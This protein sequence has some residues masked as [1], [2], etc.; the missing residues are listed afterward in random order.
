VVPRAY[1]AG[2]NVVAPVGQESSMV[3][4]KLERKLVDHLRDAHAMERNVLKMLDGMTATTSDEKLRAQLLHHSGETE[5][6]LETI[7]ARL[8]AHGASASGAKD[9]V[10][11]AGGTLSAAVMK[12]M[13]QITGD[14]R[15]APNA[16]IGFVTEHMEIAAYEV[17]ERIAVRAGDQ[18]TAHAA[19]RNRAE[20]EAMADW[21]AAGWD[22]VVDLMLAEE[23]LTT[24]ASG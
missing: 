1:S 12:V 10:A 5:R 8:R 2:Q 22:R 24:T 7:E 15:A 16:R 6:H 11:L 13:A 20:E 17:L 3:N 19:R 21:I 23:G 9:A 4:E 14:N 18:D